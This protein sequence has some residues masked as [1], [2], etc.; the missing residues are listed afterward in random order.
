MDFFYESSD[1]KS[2]PIE[3]HTK[4]SYDEIISASSNISSNWLLTS[5]RSVSTGS[6]YLI[7]DTDGNLSKV[8]VIV[9]DE[10]SIWSIASLPLKLP[11]GDYHLSNI[12]SMAEKEKLCLGWGLGTYQYAKFKKSKDCARLHLDPNIDRV[13]LKSKID[14][15][16]L[17]RDLI[18]TPAN[19]MLPTHLADAAK[20]LANDNYADFVEIVGKDLLKQN[21]PLI[22]AVGRASIDEPRLLKL[23]WGDESNP[24]VGIVGKG[25]C[26]DSGGLDIKSAAGMRWMKKDMGGA[27]HALGLANYIMANDLPVHLQVLIP[28]VENAVSGNAF[29][30][31]DV[32]TSRAGKS[33]E[34][35]NTDAEGRLV[36][37]DA[38]AELT[39]KNPDLLIDFS[40]LTGAARVALGTEVGV[41]F[42]KQD[43][44]SHELYK[45]AKKV[46]DDIWRLP[47]HEGYKDQLK[48]SIAD[49]ANCSS[50]GYGGAITAALFLNEF[51]DQDCDWLH[52]DIMAYNMRNRPGRPKGGEAIGLRSVCHFLESRYQ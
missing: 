29:R 5:N 48:S 33:V 39:E 43:K 16:N 30:P 9:P 24:L 25:V 21:Y 42:S 13:K 28:A 45:S 8:V 51:V 34:I 40:T 12:T 10:F 35:D 19:E 49:L 7:P 46:E 15:T 27:A 44:T 41:F 11:C 4:S 38:L 20:S 36:M 50:S 37:A 23:T 22:H 52:F 1:Q 6:H 31:G 14:S 26:F 17:V 18:N 32:I 2:T 3:L 47:I